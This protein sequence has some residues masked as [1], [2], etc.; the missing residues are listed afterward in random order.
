MICL[1][2]SLVLS[3]LLPEALSGQ[4]NKMKDQW[5]DD[6]EELVA[7][8]LLRAEVVSVLRNTV[9]TGK[10]TPA[11]GEEAFEAFEDASVYAGAC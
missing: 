3:W 4:A 8:A 11:E 6:G 2:A 7:P 1:D 9:Y 10:V 5:L